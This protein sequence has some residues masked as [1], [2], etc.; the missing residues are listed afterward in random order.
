MKL[1]IVRHGQTV[2]NKQKRTQGRVNNRL[3]KEGIIFSEE[4]SQ[5]LKDTRFDYIFSSPLLRSVQTANLLNK[6]HNK[7]IIKDI[8][9]TDIDQGYFTGKFFE[10]LTSEELEIKKRREKTFGMESLHEMYI[11]V[12]DFLNFLKQ[13][14]SNST[15][16]VVTHSGVAS[17]LELCIKNTN[18]NPAIFNRTDLF[19]NSEVKYFEL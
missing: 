2:W 7:K 6:Y 18:F 11:R 3:S 4:L 14:Y 16:L 12:N 9:L 5:K 13:N 1:F 17:F 19:K 15:I 10:S 8:R